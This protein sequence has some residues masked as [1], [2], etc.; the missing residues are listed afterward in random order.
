MRKGGGKAKGASFERGIC[1]TLSLWVTNNKQEDAFWRSAMSGGRST[2][3][4]KGGKRLTAQ[5]GDITATSKAGARLTDVFLLECKSYK[6]LQ[7]AQSFYK[8]LGNL[9][10]FWEKLKK[11]SRKYKRHPMLIFKQNNYPILVGLNKAGCEELM[12]LPNRLDT[13][14]PHLDLRILRLDDLTYDP[15][16]LRKK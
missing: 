8:G 6:D 9:I 10:T 1:K 5:A 2:V 13:I 3:A 14:H 16:P 4:A 15:F 11:D 7:I 12:I